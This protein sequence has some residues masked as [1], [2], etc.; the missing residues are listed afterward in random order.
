[1]APR[2]FDFPGV[3]WISA[4]KVDWLDITIDGLF[5]Q[6]CS[7]NKFRH[8]GLMRERS[9]NRS[10]GGT[11]SQVSVAST[12]TLLH[13]SAA[14]LDE[15]VSARY[16]QHSPTAEPSNEDVAIDTGTP[17]SSDYT[18]MYE[19]AGL[20]D[21][22]PTILQDSQESTISAQALEIRLTAF[23]AIIANA[24]GR[25]SMEIGLL[26][27]TDNHSKLDEDLTFT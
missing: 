11:D 10:M 2:R 13:H 25:D 8:D 4:T 6:Q 23:R 27:T 3:E 22:D 20:D 12:I 1:M 26:S 5:S 9:G 16:G 21:V 15:P 7:G 14:P 24:Q 18:Y 17:G 19:S